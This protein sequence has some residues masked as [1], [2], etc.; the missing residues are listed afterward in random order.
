MISISIPQRDALQALQDRGWT[1]I[2]SSLQH[3]PREEAIVLEVHGKDTGARMFL[4]IEPD[5]YVHS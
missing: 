5:G 1:L 4:V 3:L 2:L